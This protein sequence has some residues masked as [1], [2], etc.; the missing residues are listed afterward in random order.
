MGFSLIAQDLKQVLRTWRRQ[1]VTASA[2][3]VVLSASLALIGFML[4]T[5]LNMKRILA[6]WG[7]KVHLSV[8][9]EDDVSPNVIS[10]L[11]AKL[12]SMPD[13]RDVEMISKK[14]AADFFREQMASYAPDLLDDSEFAT[15]FPASLKV[16][17]AEGINQDGSVERMDAMAKSIGGLD[18]VEDVSYGQ[19]W[20]RSYSSFFQTVSA[21][22]AVIGLI[23]LMGSLFVIGNSVRASINQRRDEIEILELVGASREAIRRPYLIEGLIIGFIAAL[24]ALTINLGLFVWEVGLMKSSFAFARMATE[25]RY[26]NPLEAIGFVAV[27]TMIGGMASLFTVRSLNDGWAAARRVRGDA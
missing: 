2:T 7:E 6:T 25:I 8:Y 24:I 10:A 22:G 26:L 1:P 9:L 5:S 20:V 14:Q 15:P 27:A 4:V 23:L 12:K 16:H 13:V 19:S 3:L 17:L 11:Q 21:G 18:G